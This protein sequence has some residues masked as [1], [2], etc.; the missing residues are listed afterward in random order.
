MVTQKTLQRLS[1]PECL[2]WSQTNKILGSNPGFVASYVCDLGQVTE[3][4]FSHLQN[5]A[6]SLINVGEG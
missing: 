5:G 4:Q 1:K 3:T 6:T 2:L